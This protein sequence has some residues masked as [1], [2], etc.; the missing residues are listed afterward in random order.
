VG[1]VLNAEQQV[2]VA[3]R[4]PHLHQGGLWEF[5][6][7][8][9]EPGETVQQALRRELLEELAITVEAAEPLLRVE[10]DYADK[11]VVLDVWLVKGFSGTP[12]GCQGQAIQWSGVA[13]LQASDFPAANAAII[14]RLVMQCGAGQA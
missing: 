5:P 6:G 8:K 11:Q 9:L 14:E 7:G 3:K 4:A 12:L 1:V 2:L 10:H 13:E